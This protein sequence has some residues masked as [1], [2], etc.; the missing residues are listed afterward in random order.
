M[1]NGKQKVLQYL[2]EAH[3]TEQALVRVL[4][5]QIAMTPRGSYRTALETHLG[6]TRDHAERVAGRL[7]SL[8]QG[9]NPL[10]AIVGA[11]ETAI[12]QVLALGK[13]PLD[14]LRGSGG[15]E[16]VLKN[17]KDAY[18]SEALEIATYTALEHLATSVGDTETARLASSILADEERMRERILS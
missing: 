16:K 9:S 15:E 6:E 8:G 5:E 11:V 17:A 18:T 3:A 4:Q 2:D 7:Q 14:L 10:N 12:G 1:S 13:T